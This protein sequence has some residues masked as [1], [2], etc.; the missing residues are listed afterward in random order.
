MVKN[1]PNNARGARD[2]GSIDPWVGMIPGS[3]KKWQPAP[4]IL[5]GK[6]QGQRSLAGYSPWDGKR[7][8][9]NLVTK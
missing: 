7:V 8:G 9:H 1:P 5:S 2:A 3:K 6:S 4:L